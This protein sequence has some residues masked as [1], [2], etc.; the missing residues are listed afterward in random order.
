MMKDVEMGLS[1]HQRTAVERVWLKQ[2]FL[3]GDLGENDVGCWVTWDM[4]W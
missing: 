4:K 2:T 3:C 1:R